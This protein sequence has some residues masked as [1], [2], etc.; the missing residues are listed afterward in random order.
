[1]AEQKYNKI[2]IVDDHDNFIADVWYEEAMA[3]QAIRRAARIFIVNESDQVLIQQ[4]SEHVAKP[5]LLDN[6]V[7]GHVDAGETYEQAAYRELEEELG[8]TGY[9]LKE[10]QLSY[11]TY[12]FFSGVYSLRVPDAIELNF[13]PHEVKALLWFAPEEL[14]ALVTNEPERCT[15][16]MVQT[17]LELHAKIL[18][19]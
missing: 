15:K 8:L 2:Q 7:G 16:G 1:M 9:G 3:M 17:W 10:I 19:V 14:T 4:R 13:D 5:L 18:A 11:R 12:D 6:S